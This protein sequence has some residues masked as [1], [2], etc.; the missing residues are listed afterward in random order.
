VD[1]PPDV[2]DVTQEVFATAAVK[3]VDFS[4]GPAGSFRKWLYTITRHKAGDHYRRTRAQPAAAGGSAAHERLD[5]LP[6]AMSDSS[7]DGQT[8]SERAILLRRALEVVRPEFEPRTWEAAW[9]LTVEGQ[10]SADVV[11]AL[12]MS[13][14]AV[15]TAKWRVLRRLR[16]LLADLLEEESEVR[17]QKSEVRDQGS[18]VR[19]QG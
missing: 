7:A 12:S 1:R 4:A 5:E 14:G 15:H 13:A 8:V 16:E 17:G 10:C 6:A 2:E 11:A 18:E 19:N 3:L 9:R